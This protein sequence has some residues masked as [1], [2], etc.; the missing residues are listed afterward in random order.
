M[1]VVQI[2]Q[3]FE[4]T[5]PGVLNLLVLAYPQI[6]LLLLGLPLKQDCNS[7]RTPIGIRSCVDK[8]EWAHWVYFKCCVPLANSLHTPGWES[9]ELPTRVANPIWSHFSVNLS[10]F[11]WVGTTATR[12]HRYWQPNA[13]LSQMKKTMSCSI[14]F[15]YFLGG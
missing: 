6:I 7:L 3:Y 1:L 9:L 5:N 8:R 13:I 2:Q 15:L 14:Q 12:G 11:L 10:K 4:S